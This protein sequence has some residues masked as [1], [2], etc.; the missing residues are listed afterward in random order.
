MRCCSFLFW[1]AGGSGSPWAMSVW[2]EVNG[3]VDTQM[4]TSKVRLDLQA[5][6]SPLH[7]GHSTHSPLS[8]AHFFSLLCTP[9][10]NYLSVC[11]ICQVV[12]TLEPLLWLFSPAGAPTP[13]SSPSQISPVIHMLLEGHLLR[14]NAPDNPIKANPSHHPAFFSSKH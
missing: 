4:D 14:K 11:G 1:G 7:D 3:T 10:H 13:W 8:P 9:S 12:P 5:P 6:K 2:F